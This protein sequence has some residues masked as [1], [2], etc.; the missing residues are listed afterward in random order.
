MSIG[1]PAVYEQGVLR[2]LQPVRLREHQ[3]VTI[4]L[5]SDEEDW[6][7]EEIAEA[8]AAEADDSITLEQVRQDLS[9]IEGSIDN[10]LDEIRGEY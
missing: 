6:I 10:A 4:H 1:I 5:V 7:D 8:Y 3:Q 9:T 2:P